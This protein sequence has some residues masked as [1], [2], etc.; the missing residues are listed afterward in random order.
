MLGSVSLLF[1]GSRLH[2]QF[3][4]CLSALARNALVVSFAALI[5]Y[6]FEVTGYQ[7]FVLTGKTAE[8]LPPMRVPPFSVPTANG[9]ISFSEMVQVGIQLGGGARAAGSKSWCVLVLSVPLE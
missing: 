7:P 6:S 4:L 3:S 1:L 8:G 9:T 2:S 5:A